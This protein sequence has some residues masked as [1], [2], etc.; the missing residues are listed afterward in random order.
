M[1]TEKEKIYKE[2]QDVIH[3]YGVKYIM[4]F[5]E[6]FPCKHLDSSF[7]VP[8]IAD[9]NS[10]K[11][12]PDVKFLSHPYNDYYLLRF[13]SYSKFWKDWEQFKRFLKIRHFA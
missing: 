9:S 1:L 13:E 4:E 3:I 12:N 7:K 2:I 8:F 11:L 10:K 6:R 5:E